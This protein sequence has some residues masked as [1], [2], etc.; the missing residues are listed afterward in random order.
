VE[1]S[2]EV[3]SL[4]GELDAELNDTLHWIG[5]SPLLGERFSEMLVSW[6]FLMKPNKRRRL[7][8]V[9]KHVI[10]VGN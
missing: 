2:W 4:G 9:K 7:R 10:R 6:D 1:I 5:V 8:A 3:F